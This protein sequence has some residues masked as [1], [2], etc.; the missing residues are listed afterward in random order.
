MHRRRWCIGRQRYV[1]LWALDMLMFMLRCDQVTTELRSA[2][3]G[4][5]AIQGGSEAGVVGR[6]K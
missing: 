6:E 1:F 5:K 4:E 3:H 2:V